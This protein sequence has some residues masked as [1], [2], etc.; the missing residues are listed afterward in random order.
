M[1]NYT[2]KIIK[3]L[4]LNLNNLIISIFNRTNDEYDTPYTKV[5]KSEI[6]DFFKRL[7]Y[8]LSKLEKQ[9]ILI[10]S[11]ILKNQIILSW[12]INNINIDKIDKVITQII[13]KVYSVDIF[14]NIK[15]NVTLTDNENSIIK[16]SIKEKLDFYENILISIYK[17]DLKDINYKALNA[18]KELDK[19][20]YEDMVNKYVRNY[21]DIVNLYYKLTGIINK[22]NYKFAI[23][24][25]NFNIERSQFL[26]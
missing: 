16:S 20:G 23:I 6:F 8:S 5:Y 1:L 18:L 7:E 22:D 21:I 24:C 14:E 11:D 3:E 4:E 9:D 19:D 12:N 10:N 17:K 13:S 25:K 2:G 15:V 26:F